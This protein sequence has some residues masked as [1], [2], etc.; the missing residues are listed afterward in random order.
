MNRPRKQWYI[1]QL[2]PDGNGG[3]TKSHHGG[4]FPTKRRAEAIAAE[5]RAQQVSVTVEGR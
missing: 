5:Y 2:I 4:P 1:M 3:F